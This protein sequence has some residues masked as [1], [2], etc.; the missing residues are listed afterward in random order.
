MR[1]WERQRC[2]GCAS[3]VG[4]ASSG[5]TSSTVCWPGEP[6]ECGHGVRQLLLGPRVASRSPCRGRSPARGRGDATEL[7]QSRPRRWRDSD[8]VIHLA[9][10]PDIARAATEPAI[11]FDAGTLLTHHVV[12]AMRLSGVTRILYASGSGVYGDLGDVEADEDHGPL[13]PDLDLRRQQA[14][15]GG[16]HLLV[17][18][19]VRLHRVRVPLRQRG[20]SPADPRRGLRLRPPPARRTRARLTILGDGGQS[21]SY[22]HVSDVVD[23][24][25]PGRASATSEPLVRLQRRHRRL[26]H[27][28]RDRRP[29]RRGGRAATRPDGV[30]VHRAATAAGRATCRWCGSTP[31]GSARLGWANAMSASEALQASLESMVERRPVADGSHDDRHAE[32]RP[33]VFLDRDGV[34]N[35][36]VV[37]DGRPYAPRSLDE[38]ELYPDVADACRRLRGLGYVVVV[39][40][41]QPD[42]ARG[43]LDERGGARRST[44]SCAASSPSTP[45][46]SATTTTRRLCSAASRHRACSWPRPATSGSTWDGASWSGTAGGTW[47][48]AAGPVAGP[49]YID[50]H[51]RERPPRRP[52]FVASGTRRGGTVDRRMCR[53]PRG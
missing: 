36:A 16:A 27:R 2:P 30:R 45:S 5:A 50:R 46:T 49:C 42:V 12:E 14:G 25:A 52:D 28:R 4:P 24:R 34:L 21:K 37:R 35:D 18:Q 53:R 22:V 43:E 15:R 26:H 6:T 32:S 41:N 48:R 10:N 17:L 51:Y 38:F 7:D 3:S 19:H 31:T 40:T 47:R 29:G 44:V 9:S 39:V 13:P 8:T 33:A 11:D 20:R 1:A 23:G